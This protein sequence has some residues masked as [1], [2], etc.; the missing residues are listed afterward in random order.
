[1]FEA[2]KD[3]DIVQANNNTQTLGTQR[4]QYGF[5]ECGENPRGC[6]QPNRQNMPLIGLVL[7]N[8]KEQWWWL[9]RGIL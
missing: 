6:S 5:S 8:H 1:M 3:Q 9:T 2:N 7:Q 4:E